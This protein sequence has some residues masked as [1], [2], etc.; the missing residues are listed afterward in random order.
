[1]PK[2]VI[3]PSSRWPGVVVLS[4]P[5]TVSQALEFERALRTVSNLSVS[6]SELITEFDMAALPAIL[7]C[8][9]KWELEGIDNPPNPFPGSPRLESTKLTSWIWGEILAVWN[10]S[11]EAQ[12]PNE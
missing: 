3:S 10:G 6:K 7:A 8:V 1:M 5:M 11:G 12:D 4:D 9:E 2:K